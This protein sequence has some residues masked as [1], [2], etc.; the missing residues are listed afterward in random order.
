M[1]YIRGC[2]VT[3][4]ALVWRFSLVG[5]FLQEF[6]ALQTKVIILTSLFHCVVLC[7]NGSFKLIQIND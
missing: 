6:L 5:L 1:A 3:L 7:P 4:V 2:I